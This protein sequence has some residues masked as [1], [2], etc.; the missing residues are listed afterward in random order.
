M[1]PSEQRLHKFLLGKGIVVHRRGWPDFLC[2]VKDAEGKPQAVA[3]ELKTI[4]CA[5]VSP[6]QKAVH[7]VLR[8]A[9]I[10]TCTIVEG[11]PGSYRVL[12]DVPCLKFA[13]ETPK[14][15]RG[16]YEHPRGSDIWWVCWFDSKGKR[17][18]E[19][20]GTIAMAMDLYKVRKV[21]VMKERFE[22]KVA[23]AR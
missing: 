4:A 21:S 19:K 20:A 10:P 16:V 9:G 12:Q 11:M 7:A 6:E 17:H 15:P 14:K 1:T 3:V 23:T 8:M 22:R 13:V 5:E 2:V 18:R